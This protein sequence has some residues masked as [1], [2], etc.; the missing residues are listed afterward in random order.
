MY[1]CPSPDANDV[2]KMSVRHF[3][4]DSQK[5]SL[6]YSLG[7]RPLS[8]KGYVIGARTAQRFMPQPQVRKHTSTGRAAASQGFVGC[9]HLQHHL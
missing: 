1:F 8:N 3:G 9:S 2:L 5:S 4:F 7:N 6:R